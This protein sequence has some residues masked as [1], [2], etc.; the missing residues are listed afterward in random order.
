MRITHLHI[1]NFRCFPSLEL[2]FESK[3][4]L[5]AGLNGTGKT[6]LLEALH[7]L[8]YLRSFRTHI[9]QDLV[10]FGSNTFFLKIQVESDSPHELQ[11]GFGNKKRLVKINNKAIASYKELLTYYRVVTLT[12]DDLDLIKGNPEVRRLFMD[13]VILLTDTDFL[14]VSK[15]NKE[16]VDQRNAL[17]KNGGSQ[18][19]YVLW[20]E[21][22]WDSSKMVQDARIVALDKLE[23]EIASI[24]ATYFNN[25]YR[26]TFT[27]KPKKPLQES[28]EAFAA[29]YPMLYEE[30]KRFA[31]SLFGSHLD[32]FTIQFRDVTS[33]SF[34][35]RGQQKLIVVLLKAAQVRLLALHNRPAILLLDDFMTDFDKET[36]N[37]LIEILFSL[38]IQLVFTVPSPGGM[39]ETELVRR[40]AQLIN[41]D[42]MKTF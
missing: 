31:R 8:C 5:I 24:V 11:V 18:E 7:Y 13:Q 12:E 16:I 4:L 30:E 17:L 33:R 32:D 1:K 20:T 6:S 21:Q 15:Q 34:A 40:K 38:N 27:Y 41:I 22:L 9:P 3:S 19:S 29:R 42:N 23:K 28:F 37:I 26:I 36:M 39:L 35:S 2:S 25:M 10:R 14:R